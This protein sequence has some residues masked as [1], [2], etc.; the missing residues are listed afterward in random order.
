MNITR[1]TKIGELIEQ[2]PQAKAFLLMNGLHCAGCAAN[3]FDT[4]ESGGRIHRWPEE[5]IDELVEE[6]NK[7]LGEITNQKSQ[8]PNKHQ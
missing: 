6:L 2:Y 8:V 3:T 7:Y 1:N 4:I 5:E